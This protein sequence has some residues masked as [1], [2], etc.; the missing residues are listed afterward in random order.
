M[1]MLIKKF[2]WLLLCLALTTHAIA[3]Q[4][5]MTT[6]ASIHWLSSSQLTVLLAGRAFQ[7]TRPDGMTF[8][9][10]FYTNHKIVGHAP[11]LK[12]YPHDTG[13]WQIE[14]NRYCVTWQIWGNTK[15]CLRIRQIGLGEYVSRDEHNYEKKMVESR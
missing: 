4:P 3:Q 11:S 15:Q 6:N 10:I 12:M 7:V 5:M 13:T 2:V 8:T 14:G 1:E 9:E